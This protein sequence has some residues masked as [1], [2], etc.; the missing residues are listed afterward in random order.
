MG[1]AEDNRIVRILAV[2]DEQGILDA[3]QTI[4]GGHQ[5]D[6]NTEEVQELEAKLFS[7]G[8]ADI[9]SEKP[10]ESFDL[11]VCHQVDQA[12]EAV[13]NGL[14]DGNPFGV[15]FLDMRMPP[16]S[17]G[18][19]T[20]KKIHQIDPNVQ[21]VIV[22]GYSDI[23]AAEIAKT[24]PPTEKLLYIQKPFQPQELRQFASVFGAKWRA[25]REL[26]RY[27]HD[28]E[29]L[30]KVRTE[31]LSM[32]LDA[33][34][35]ANQSKSDFLAG[36]SHEIRTP[37]N[38]IMGFCEMLN[39]EDLTDVQHKYV[40]IIHNSSKSLLGLINDILDLSRIESGK[41]DIDITDCSVKMLLVDIEALLKPAAAEKGLALNISQGDVPDVIQTD[42]TRLRQCLINLVNNA[43]KFTK[44]GHVLVKA[45][46]EDND[47]SGYVRFDV[48]DTGIGIKM[49]E[50]ENIFESF[51]Q[52]SVSI[53]RKFG[54]SG[55]G[56]AISKQLACLLGGDLTM[57]SEVGHGSVFSLRISTN[58]EKKSYSLS[59]SPSC[60]DNSPAEVSACETLSGKVL[61][62]EDF[63]ANWKLLE[64][65]LCRM[66]LDAVHA[67]DGNEV[68]REVAEGSIDLVLMD[69]QM[70]NL[71]GCDTTK[72]LREND[73]T[74]PIIAVTAFAMSGD[75][76]KCLKAGCNDYITKPVSFSDLEHILNKYL[77]RTTEMTGFVDSVTSQVDDLFDLCDEGRSQESVQDEMK[78]KFSKKGDGDRSV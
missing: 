16:G 32:A 44:Q 58:I 15:I 7:D 19:W 8:D 56:L 43:I 41:L 23:D 1:S 33:A 75:R 48:E 65:M 10:A 13:R 27:H 62:A 25:E 76:E 9:A 66:G 77:R 78:S 35:K 12:V 47:G 49:E 6:A 5:S 72:M 39:E 71:N 51:S 36:M 26:Q 57:K 54:G 22:T 21:I 11:S 31:E 24:V 46:L 20:A 52:S 69:I 42:P 45:Y 59:G 29:D 50:Q 17:D 14:S 18:L 63:E 68:I 40:N 60:F 28:L 74:I 37:M 61:V 3:Y 53:T 55:L 73:I 34:E 4:L 70:P 38:A 67:K 64:V 30:V 2:D